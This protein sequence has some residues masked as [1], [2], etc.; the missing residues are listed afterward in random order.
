ML[1][2][3]EDRNSKSTVVGYRSNF[4]ILINN[5]SFAFKTIRRS[6]KRPLI[7]L[8]PLLKKGLVAFSVFKRDVLDEDFRNKNTAPRRHTELVEGG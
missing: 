4:R 3:I 5:N 6:I 7:S 2:N 1:T 8:V